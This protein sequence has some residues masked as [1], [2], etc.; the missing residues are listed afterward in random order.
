MHDIVLSV[1]Q[2]WL[3]LHNLS[4]MSSSLLGSSH[5]RGWSV[6]I[7]HSCR[8]SANWNLPVLSITQRNILPQ[9]PFNSHLPTVWSEIRFLKGMKCLWYVNILTFIILTYDTLRDPVS[10][11][12]FKLFNSVR[13]WTWTWLLWRVQ[14]MTSLKWTIL[15][16]LS[17]KCD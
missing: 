6:H 3:S 5:S 10:V 7:F 17:L 16:N 13:H 8:D 11:S 1:S 9:S 4:F 15:K 12:C 2:S 14:K